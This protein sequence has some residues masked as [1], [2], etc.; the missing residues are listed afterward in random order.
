[1]NHLIIKIIITFMLLIILFIICF[2]KFKL[3][4]KS[5]NCESFQN[6]ITNILLNNNI[7]MKNIC[8]SAIQNI[9]IIHYIEILTNK[10]KINIE[11][12]IYHKDR[13]NIQNNKYL[14]KEF[15]IQSIQQISENNIKINCDKLILEINKKLIKIKPKIKFKN[16]NYFNTNFNFDEMLCFYSYCNS[17]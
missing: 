13:E 3:T 7:E 9:E 6:L 16:Y 8:Y 4:G 10:S 2:D 15:I 12:Q 17:I 5:I 1:M 14:N 11:V